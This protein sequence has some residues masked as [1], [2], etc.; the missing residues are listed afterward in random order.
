MAIKFILLAKKTMLH[1]KEKHQ[2]KRLVRPEHLNHH[3]TLFAGIGTQWF[4]ESSYIAAA[5]VINPKFLVCKK[6]DSLLFSKPVQSGQII[7]LES[8][9]EAV[10][11]TSITTYTKVTLNNSKEI[12]VDGHIVFVHVD[13]N[14]KPRKHELVMLN[15]AF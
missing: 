14:T 6:I 10:G 2:T 9:I 13:E 3:G 11:S 4:V 5:S 12:L 8:Y 15:H 1:G 7:V